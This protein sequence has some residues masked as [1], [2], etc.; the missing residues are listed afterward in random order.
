MTVVLVE[1]TVGDALQASSE[2]SL[3]MTRKA[4]EQ[5]SWD[6]GGKSGRSQAERWGHT[7]VG[8]MGE[9]AACRVLN[10]C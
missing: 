2:A 4:S 7:V 3:Q 1:L 9:I 6:H 5:R 8:L 10:L